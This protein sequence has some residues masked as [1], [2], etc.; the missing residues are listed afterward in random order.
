M[1]ISFPSPAIPN[2]ARFVLVL[3]AHPFFNPPAPAPQK[4]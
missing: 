4:M 1:N 3:H 2:D